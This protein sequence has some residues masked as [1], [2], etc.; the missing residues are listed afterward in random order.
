MARTR[1]HGFVQLAFF[2]Y[3][4]EIYYDGETVPSWV[5]NW[6]ALFCLFDESVYRVNA[7]YDLFFYAATRGSLIES[8]Y[9]E[10]A[11]L[12]LDDIVPIETPVTVQEVEKTTVQE[13]MTMDVI[14]QL[15]GF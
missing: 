6:T 4:A 13:I 10:Y 2:F 8:W 3:Q 11:P 5:Y 14:V 9:H 15:N 7:T 12:K 1:C